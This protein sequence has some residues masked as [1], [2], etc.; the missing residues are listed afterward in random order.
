MASYK[1]QQ[2][3]QIVVLWYK[4]LYT[5]LRNRSYDN[6]LKDL[7]ELDQY[8]IKKQKN[9]AIVVVYKKILIGFM[10]E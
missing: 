2:R 3:A 7:K 8:K 9:V 5:N 6:L 10:R 1:I 4:N